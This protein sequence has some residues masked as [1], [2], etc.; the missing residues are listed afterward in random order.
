MKSPVLLIIFNR[1]DTT[2]QVLNAIRKH[3]PDKLYVFC[4]GPRA[5]SVA[6]IKL[7]NQAKQIVENVDWPC[8]VSRK[9]LSENLGCGP[10]PATAISWALEQEDRIIILE[11]DC[12]PVQAFFEF[13][14]E[15]L[16][17]YLNDNRIAAISGNNPYEEIDLPASYV[18]SNYG[19][20]W[21]WATWKRAWTGFDLHW[22]DLN[23]FVALGGFQCVFHSQR[24][25]K[26]FNRLF[27]SLSADSK[28]WT[29]A[30]DFQANYNFKKQ[31][32]LAI[33][34]AKNLVTNIGLVGT[35]SRS[36]G[37]YHNRPADASY[38]ISNHP[39]FVLPFLEYEQYHFYHHFFKHDRL[40]GR[41]RRFSVR[42]LTRFRKIS[43]YLGKR[44]M[45]GLLN[46]LHLAKD[47][48][49]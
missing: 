14:D 34:P 48:N 46:Y 18:F 1:P 35:H 10:G 25:G 27:K 3:Q 8:K 44:D 23:D 36:L 5:G 38:R 26:F 17:R 6:D 4:D 7:S 28:L 43:A 16:E 9:Y 21:G 11:D 42:A 31:G 37:L 20:S 13:C 39:Q 41:V 32:G 29:H 19:H 40:L 15:L 24:E 22:K 2:I 49:K 30:W 45:L 33:V 47:R 12:V